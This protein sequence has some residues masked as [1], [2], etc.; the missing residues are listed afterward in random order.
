MYYLI[1]NLHSYILRVDLNLKKIK[2]HE[3]RY[4]LKGS[5]EKPFHVVSKIHQQFLMHIYDS[6]ALG[7]LKIIKIANKV[8]VIL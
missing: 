2:S 3:D 5:K 6:V 1:G 8:S 7:I 4:V